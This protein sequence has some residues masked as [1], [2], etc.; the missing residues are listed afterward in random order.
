MIS[1]KK[2]LRSSRI[3]ILRK[4]EKKTNNWNEML[5][6]LF[7]FFS[8]HIFYCLSKKTMNLWR[9]CFKPY[10]FLGVL[11]K[12]NVTCLGDKL[13]TF[14]QKAFFRSQGN[15]WCLQFYTLEAL[16][17]ASD[18]QCAVEVLTSS[19]RGGVLF[20]KMWAY[21]WQCFLFRLDCLPL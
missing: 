13:S 14:L 17:G 15:C 5:L 1:Y 2:L 4:D 11:C 10:I 8:T 21:T 3:K 19:W 20:R 7:I 18:V 12:Q 6:L 9:F 16:G